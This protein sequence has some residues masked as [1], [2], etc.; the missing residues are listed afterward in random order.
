MPKDE[1]SKGALQSIAEALKTLADKG[2]GGLGGNLGDGPA[3]GLFELAAA[4]GPYERVIITRSLGTAT[5]YIRNK[6]DLYIVPNGR[7][8]R[9]NGDFAGNYVGV[10][11]SKV[12]DDLFTFPPAPEKPYDKPSPI[13]DFRMKLHPTKAIW[14]LH[15]GSIFAV[16]PAN[17]YVIPL[18]DQSAQL[19]ISIAM[20]ITGGTR[21][22]EG[23]RGTISSLGATW[24]P[25]IPGIGLDKT[26]KDG[27]VFE[28]KGVHGMRI[29]LREDQAPAPGASDQEDQGD[30]DDDSDGDSDSD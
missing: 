11:K 30:G 17:S 7:L 22:F 15:E 13:P 14:R 23:A 18:R 9:L 3:G 19:V 4:E 20:V 16:G 28:A 26:L 2:G 25:F 1:G 24:F 21:R 29:T 10:F 27:A 5:V 8:H 12:G 6:V